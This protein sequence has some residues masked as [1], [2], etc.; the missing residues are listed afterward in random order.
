MSL[1]TSQN[2]T[3]NN[4]RAQ[5]GMENHWE[6]GELSYARLIHVWD[7]LP[8]SCKHGSS[9]REGGQS[10]AGKSSVSEVVKCQ[11]GEGGKPLCLWK[12]GPSL[13]HTL[14]LSKPEGALTGK[15]QSR[16]GGI[17]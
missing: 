11:F 2:D 13:Q 6:Q 7:C 16:G 14:V 3:K 4:Q 8:S 12:P 5:A 17:P 1:W 15:E 10:L 9:G